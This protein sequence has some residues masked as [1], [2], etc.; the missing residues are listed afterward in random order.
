MGSSCDSS[1]PPPHFASSPGSAALKD[2]KKVGFDFGDQFAEGKPWGGRP[3]LNEIAFLEKAGPGTSRADLWADSQ[4]KN[5]IF[6]R[7]NAA[8]SPDDLEFLE[9]LE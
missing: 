8:V 5:D 9:F 2:G 7:L 1:C 4:I 6:A 3:I